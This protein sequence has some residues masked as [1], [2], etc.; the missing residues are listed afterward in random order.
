MKLILIASTIV[1]AA[2]CHN[3]KPA[4]QKQLDMFE[5]RA[6]AFA[7]LV[8]P[9]FDAADVARDAIAGKVDPR[10]IAAK[11]GASIDAIN[12]AVDSWNACAPSAE[13][14]GP[15]VLQAS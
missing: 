13:P 6:A 11:L 15:V 4:Q 8:E 7:P 3:L 1:L 9:A 14:V 10:Q 2:G 12:A 5:C